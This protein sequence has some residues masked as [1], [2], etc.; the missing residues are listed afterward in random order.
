[1]LGRTVWFPQTQ[2][3]G[4]PFRCTAV[5]KPANVALARELFKNLNVVQSMNDGLVAS[6][7]GNDRGTPYRFCAGRADFDSSPLVR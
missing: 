3:L 2:I 5:G 4:R 6:C 1:M 7:G